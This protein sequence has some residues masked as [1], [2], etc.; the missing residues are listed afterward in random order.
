MQHMRNIATR[1][2]DIQRLQEGYEQAIERMDDDAYQAGQTAFNNAQ[3]TAGLTEQQV[4]QQ[5][6]RA[7]NNFIRR[8]RAQIDATMHNN[9]GHLQRDLINEVNGAIGEINGALTNDRNDQN[10]GQFLQAALN[11]ANQQ[12]NQWA[13]QVAAYI[14]NYN[15][16]RFSFAQ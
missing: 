1:A 4:Q 2:R 3:N 8:R 16:P 12:N 11:L 13:N 14:T 7:Y 5:A 10:L 9:L 6:Q 15:R